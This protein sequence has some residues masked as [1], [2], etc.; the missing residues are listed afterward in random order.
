[1]NARQL[2]IQI[3]NL[4]DQHCHF[5]E[6]QSSS[7]AY[8]YANCSVG[9]WIQQ[10]GIKLLSFSKKEDRENFHIKRKKE[11]DILCEKAM[12]LK[13]THKTYRAIAK[14]F[15]CDE[16]GLRKQLKKRGLLFRFREKSSQDICE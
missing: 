10:G 6:F 4:Q 16:S 14:V 7:Y 13:D 11:W 2:R 9:K 8:C 3:L 12:E 5:C 1:M 15:G